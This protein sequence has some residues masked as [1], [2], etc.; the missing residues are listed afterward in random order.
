MKK[1]KNIIIIFCILSVLIMSVGYSTFA[2]EIKLE[3]NAEII[4]VWDIRVTNIEIEDKSDSAYDNDLSFTDN[5]VTF[6]S[7]L[8]KPGDYINYKVTVKNAG[9]IDALLTNVLCISD[10]ENG[11]PAILYETTNLKSELPSG[12][13]TTFNIIVTYDKNVTQLPEIKSKKYTGFIEYEQ[14]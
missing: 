4:G 11:S 10:D 1:G 7:K 12:E 9:T 13:T 14:K 5:T 2:T 3:G 8:N 6:N